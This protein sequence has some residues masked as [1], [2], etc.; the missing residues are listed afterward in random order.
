MS[1]NSIIEYI[2][3]AL[4]I[5]HFA[6]SN[7]IS[8]MKDRLGSTYVTESVLRIEKCFLK[9][10][11]KICHKKAFQILVQNCKLLSH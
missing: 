9:L 3:K 2:Q 4:L 8:Q 10:A 7:Q 11:R 1:A 5:T 6:T